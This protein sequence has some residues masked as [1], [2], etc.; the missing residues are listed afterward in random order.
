M[1]SVRDTEEFAETSHLLFENPYFEI[2][3]PPPRLTP[4]QKNYSFPDTTFTEHFP[5]L[6]FFFFF[7]LAHWLAMRLYNFHVS[8]PGYKILSLITHT[9]PC[10]TSAICNSYW[11]FLPRTKISI[12]LVKLEGRYAHARMLPLFRQPF[13]SLTLYHC[14][15]RHLQNILFGGFSCTFETLAAAYMFASWVPGEP[16]NLL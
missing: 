8:F 4:L 12:A 3:N 1:I 15:A 11:L 6:F 2:P 14:A 9:T 5:V 16:L 13:F 7:F 10:L